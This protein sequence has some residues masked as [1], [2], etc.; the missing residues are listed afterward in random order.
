MTGLDWFIVIIINGSIVLWGLV[1]ARGT[2]RSVDW[3]LAA[4]GLPWWIVGLSMFA[5]AVDSGDYVAVVGGAYNYGLTNLTAWWI[6]LPLGWFLGGPRILLVNHY[7]Y[8]VSCLAL[9]SHY[10]FYS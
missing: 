1:L 7:M 4:R 5:T 6:G 10:K 8:M 3:F 2:Q 9:F